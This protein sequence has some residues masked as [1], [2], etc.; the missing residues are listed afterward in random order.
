MDALLGAA[1]FGDIGQHFPDTNAAYKDAS[2]LCMLAEVGKLLATDSW[3]IANIDATII[4]QSPKLSPYREDMKRNIAK[5]LDILPKSV[6]IKFTTEE[7]LGFTGACQGIAAQ[8]ACLI[9]NH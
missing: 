9:S 3:Q 1:G 4:C 8:A 7:G 6:N 5:T 2:S